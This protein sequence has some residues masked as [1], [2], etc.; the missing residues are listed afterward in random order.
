M[1][2]RGERAADQ[3]RALAQVRRIAP[4]MDLTGRTLTVTPENSVKVSVVELFKHGLAAQTLTLWIAFLCSFGAIAAMTQWTPVLLSMAGADATSAARTVAF[5]GAGSVIGILAGSYLAGKPGSFWIMFASLV[6]A[7]L[8]L[9]VLGYDL[10]AVLLAHLMVLGGSAFISIALAS[11]FA[12]SATIY[13]DKVRS[14]GVGFGFAMS[15]AGNVGGLA[16]AGALVAANV[17]ASG[18][19]ASLSGVALV[20]AVSSLVLWLAINRFQTAVGLPAK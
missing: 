1:R 3:A 2:A 6:G 5:G 11:L 15:R 18:V 20:A 16:L 4:D 17:P 7:G 19:M 8:C 12:L 10:Q 13:P 9:L 14:T